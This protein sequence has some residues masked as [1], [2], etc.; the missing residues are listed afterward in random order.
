MPARDSVRDSL[1]SETTNLSH[2]QDEVDYKMDNVKLYMR[3]TD[4]NL[5]F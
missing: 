5:N 2:F 3:L 1:A 4:K